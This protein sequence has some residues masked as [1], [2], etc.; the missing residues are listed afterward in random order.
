MSLVDARRRVAA[1][2]PFALLCF[3]VSSRWLLESKLPTAGSTLL[4]QSAGCLL[5]AGVVFIRGLIRRTSATCTWVP[6][7]SVVAA[8]SLVITAPA[9]CSAASSRSL[10][11]EN[12][13]LA[14]ALTPVVVAVA[15]SAFG[16]AEEGDL[17]ARLWPGLVGTAGLLLILPAPSFTSWRFGLAL[18]S[19]PLVLGTGA[20]WVTRGVDRSELLTRPAWISQWQT[21]AFVGAAVV[22]CLLAFA[23][24]QQSLHPSFSSVAAS[25]DAF[26]LLLTLEVLSSRRA[27][28]WSAQFL[29]VPLLALLEGVFVMRPLLTARSY[30]A[31]AM[32]AVSS[33]GQWCIKPEEPRQSGLT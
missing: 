15:S 16:E 18:S 31:L 24:W 8:A 26:T 22:L 4:T 14:L 6:S 12:V 17:G 30:L 19:M 10:N 9:V 2:L 23:S 5:A 32:L 28:P 20:A 1:T 13:M 29:F 21:W 3:T 25:L 11:A 27:S 7:A 33:A